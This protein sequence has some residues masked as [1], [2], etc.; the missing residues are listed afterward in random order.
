MAIECA[1][2][3]RNAIH[4]RIRAPCTPRA[5]HRARLVCTAQQWPWQSKLDSF[6]SSAMHI[7]IR[8]P[9]TP[10]APRRARL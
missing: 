6:L 5:L 4:M 2:M 7:K 10:R 3:L 9:C 8:S 1:G